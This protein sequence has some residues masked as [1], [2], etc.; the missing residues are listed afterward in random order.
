MWL[1]NGYSSDWGGSP[2]APKLKHQAPAAVRGCK[3]MC[4][5]M[6]VRERM[7][8]CACTRARPP[9]RHTLVCRQAQS[10]TNVQPHMHTSRHACTKPFTEM[11]TRPKTRNMMTRRQAHTTQHACQH[12]CM[13]ARTNKCTHARTHPASLARLLVATCLHAHTNAHTYA[14]SLQH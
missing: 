8:T 13:H 2:T 5:H 14:R 9:A 7:L 1:E 3:R 10:H 4:R 6:I 12:T 11:T